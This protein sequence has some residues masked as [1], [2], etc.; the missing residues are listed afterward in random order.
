MRRLAR[1][2]GALRSHA[3]DHPLIAAGAGTLVGEIRARAPHV[4]TIVVAAGGGGLFAGVATAAAEHGIRVVAVEPERCCALHA[5]LRAGEPVDVTVESIAADSLGARRATG[6]AVHAAQRAGAR[7]VLV[8]D[9]AIVAARRTLW[10]QRRIVVEHGA[11]AAL[12]GLAAYRPADGERVVVVLCGANTDP[13]DLPNRRL[14]HT[15]LR[16]ERQP[17]PLSECRSEAKPAVRRPWRP[18]DRPLHGG[19]G[20]RVARD[21]G[22]ATVVIAREVR[23]AGGG[24]SRAS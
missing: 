7:S 24:R 18:A 6:L 2:S 9:A 4:E 19:M 14:R 3:Y 20:F 17:K 16:S 8:S 12:A 22:G 23:S 11:A 13:S 5:A 1:E 15:T 21:S 10:E